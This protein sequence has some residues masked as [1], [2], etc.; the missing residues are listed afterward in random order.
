MYIAYVTYIWSYFVIF[1][2]Y[3]DQYMHRIAVAL[4]SLNKGGIAV[5]LQSRGAVW[6]MNLIKLPDITC[7]IQLTGCLKVNLAKSSDNE[8]GNLAESLILTIIWTKLNL[9]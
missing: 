5:A 6:D 1:G 2:Q 4:Q 9:T 7:S 8:S 3:R